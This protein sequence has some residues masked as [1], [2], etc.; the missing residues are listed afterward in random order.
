VLIESMPFVVL[1]VL[2]SI[3]VQVWVPPGRSSAGCRGAPWARRMVLS[4]L[5][6][7]VPV[8][9]CGNVPF[10]RGLMMRGFTV[11]RR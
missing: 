3:V 5:G 7:L 1:G 8:C 11:P 4:L 2:L 9:E 6:M 10:A